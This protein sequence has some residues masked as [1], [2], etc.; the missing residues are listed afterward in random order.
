MPLNSGYTVKEQIEPG[1]AVAQAR[2]ASMPGG[3][4][5]GAVP[6]GLGGAGV[7]RG[8]P[9]ERV[10]QRHDRAVAGRATPG[11]GTGRGNRA[12]QHP[13]RPQSADELHGQVGQQ[14]CQTGDVVA[15]VEHD[16]DIRVARSPVP[17]LTQPVHDLA[18]LGGGDRGGTVGGT[19]TDRVQHRGPAAAAGLQRGHDRVRPA[20]DHLGGPPRPA[21]D[22]A[23]QPLRAGLGVGAQPRRDVDGQH[24]PLPEPRQRQSGHTAPE[25]GDLNLAVVEPV[26]EG[27]VPTAMLRGQR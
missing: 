1:A 21:V 3:G 24:D 26:V 6:G 18:Q 16:P 8:G 20:R 4:L 27:A 14:E 12:G 23:E 9:G 19:Q 15:G 25:S 11:A 17:G 13:V 5:R 10:G 7:L 22:M 2:V